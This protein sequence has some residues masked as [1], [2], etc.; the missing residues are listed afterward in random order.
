VILRSAL[1]FFLFCVCALPSASA[2]NGV[3]EDWTLRTGSPQSSGLTRV[4]YGAGIY[5]AVGND[6]LH[7]IIQTSR[8]SKT[9]KTVRKVAYHLEGAS[10]EGGRFFAVGTYGTV[11]QSVDAET[12]E[13]QS[14]GD[15]VAFYDVTYGQ[16][17]WVLTGY[18]GVIFSSTNC[19]N[20]TV[21][22]DTSDEPQ[23]IAEV[24]PA[25]TY[26][27]G[28]FVVAAETGSILTSSDGI[29]WERHMLGV[30]VNFLDA[31]FAEN[32]FVVVSRNG[33]VLT[34]A[35]GREWSVRSSGTIF[36]LQA[37]TY[38]NGEFIA[39]GEK[40]I[41]ITSPD[42]VEWALRNTGRLTDMS[43]VAS[44]VDG[45]VAVSYTGPDLLVSIDGRSWTPALSFPPTYFSSVA[46]GNG[47]F[48]A[49]GGDGTIVRSLDGAEWK[50]SESG[51]LAYLRSVCY[52]DQGLFIVV[53]DSATI[54]VSADGVAWSRR[55]LNFD[56]F[57]HLYGVCSG[58]N[59]VV[60][61]GRDGNVAY[62]DNGFRWSAY[63]RVLPLST[64]FY[65]VYSGNGIFLAAGDNGRL[66]MTQDGLTWTDVT[67][68][69]PTKL[70]ALLFAKNAFYALGENGNLL[71][72]TNGIAWESLATN[73][74]GSPSAWTYG[75]ETFVVVSDDLTIL[76]SESGTNWEIQQPAE[77]PLFARAIAFG[78][79]SFVVCGFNGSIA[80]SR[81]V[82]V[83]FLRFDT[84]RNLTIYGKVGA[85]YTIQGS[86]DFVDW[87]NV[88]RHT[89]LT[90]EHD[91][92]EI[93]NGSP[94]LK[95]LR[96]VLD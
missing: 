53:G 75:N 40:G 81:K 18:P 51:S 62:T 43:G 35:D 54:L 72:S 1:A 64:T 86:S 25:A 48:V 66:A 58:S 11:L 77:F 96:A 71:I 73:F 67:E 15:G 16:G 91:V 50:V 4:A 27:D 61:V 95:F 55:D 65:N 52:T 59:R 57:T 93:L 13:E 32:S 33:G 87:T 78:N 68:N 28:L 39:V 49:V 94:K 9:W 23:R 89:Q 42:G 74:R 6:G 41:F 45:L 3:L 92:S 14:L 90:P 2:G 85:G 34:S 19:S 83:P 70:V 30:P 20:W 47:I 12:W 88:S 10:Y 63:T 17:V 44:G 36:H 80:Q 79:D 24:F 60:A 29:K 69:V 8:D 31:F 22:K 37:I 21:R 46:Y 7:G 26:G 5:V 76:T 84:D 38:H 82:S 56:R